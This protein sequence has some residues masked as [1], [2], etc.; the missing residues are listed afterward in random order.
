MSK[1]ENYVNPSGP[2]VSKSGKC[3]GVS[4]QTNSSI[5][6]GRN[7]LQSGEIHF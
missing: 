6:S 1:F 7:S 4:E 5:S 3:L 2:D